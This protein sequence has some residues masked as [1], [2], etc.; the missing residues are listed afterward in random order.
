MDTAGIPF[1]VLFMVWAGWF[2]TIL[3]ALSYRKELGGL[4]SGIQY[5]DGMISQLGAENLKLKEIVKVLDETVGGVTK[6]LTENIEICEKLL[7]YAP[8]VFNKYP[9]IAYWLQAHDE[10]FDAV[11]RVR[12]GEAVDRLPNLLLSKRAVQLTQMLDLA[13]GPEEFPAEPDEISDYIHQGHKHGH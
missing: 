10:F 5:R 9:A 8:A 2:L 6:R 1:G 3:C 13:T 4:R 12:G 11:C 7:E